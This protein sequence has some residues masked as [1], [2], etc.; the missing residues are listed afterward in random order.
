M[1]SPTS[2]TGSAGQRPRGEQNGRG[3]SPQ[4]RVAEL[5]RRGQDAA[6]LPLRAF[7]GG[8]FVFA[9][10]QK[11]ANPNFFNQSSPISIWAQL[12]GAERTSPIR[13]LLGHLLRFS[14]PLGFVIA[15]GEV[16]VGLGLLLGLLTRVAAAGGMLLSFGLF[17]TVSFHSNP[18]YTGADIVFFFALSPLLLAGPGELLALDPIVARRAAELSRARSTRRAGRPDYA[19]T[20]GTA[21]PAG[22]DVA[23]ARRRLLTRAAAGAGALGLAA[24]GLDGLIGRAIGAAGSPRSTPRLGG[25][26]APG[27]TGASRATTTAP[28]TSP[29]TTA[30]VGSTR[31]T[32]ATPPGS[33]LGPA[34]DVPVGGSAAFTDPATGDPGI[35]IQQTAGHFVAFDAV[36]PHAGCT[37]GY[38]PANSL[39]VCPCHGSEF[40]PASGAVVAGPHQGACG[41]SRYPEGATG[42]STPFEGAR[43][44][45]A[46]GAASSAV[47]TWAGGAAHCTR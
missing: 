18:Y 34:K 2:P 9:G 41:R 31:T 8:T 13:S 42:T 19:G 28:A 37:V 30:P 44:P 22:A 5:D 7:L 26:A 35:V 21:G 32:T 36:C 43:V 10:L 12:V 39:I 25:S 3:S 16:A 45:A 17:L 27:A 47:G 20:S 33:A 15:A 46:T 38:S 6:F 14:T 11:L 29:P 1:P 4:T 23:L 24:M 40:N